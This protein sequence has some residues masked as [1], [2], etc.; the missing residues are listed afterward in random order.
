M[1]QGSAP[2]EDQFPDTII[3]RDDVLYLV[4]ILDRGQFGNRQDLRIFLLVCDSAE[5]TLGI[6]L[7]YGGNELRAVCRKYRRRRI[8]AR[9]YQ[10]LFSTKYLVK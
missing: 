8:C 7:T 9:S 5:I 10:V 1:R 3:G 4:G 2:T 6:G